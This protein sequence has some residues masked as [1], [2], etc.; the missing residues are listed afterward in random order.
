M[1]PDIVE[2]LLRATAIWAVLLAY[3]F[4]ALRRADFRFQRVYLLGGGA[5]WYGCPLTAC[6]GDGWWFAGGAITNGYF[7]GTGFRSGSRRNGNGDKLEL[8]G[9]TPLAVRI[10]R[11]PFGGADAGAVGVD[12]AMVCHR[13]TV[14]LRRFS[15]DSPRRD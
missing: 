6:P 15:G 2:Y 3:Y 8:D 7:Q 13:A 10:R 4:L 14:K 12:L 5:V 11:D 9:P 1:S